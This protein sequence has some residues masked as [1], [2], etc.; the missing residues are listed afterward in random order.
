MNLFT[1]TYDLVRQI[2]PGKI[3]TYGAVAKALGDIRASR[4]VG[5]MMN[6]NPDAETMPCYKIIHSDGKLGG[7]GLGTDDK[8][9]R[10]QQD[11]IHVK[12]GKIQGFTNVFF[13]DFQ[14]TYPLYNFQ[15]EQ[16]TLSHQ[17]KT[18]DDFHNIETIGGI[19]VAYPQNEFEPAC[20]AYILMN[21]HTKEI[22]EQTT[23]TAPT[24]FPY[25]PG[26]LTYRELPLIQAVAHQWIHPPDVLMIDGNGILHPRGCGLASHAGLTLDLPTIG[27]AKNLLLGTL[28][29]NRIMVNGIPLGITL[30]SSPHAK[31]PLYLS[32]GHRISLE[33]CK[34]VVQHCCHTKH[35]EPLKQAHHLA[36]GT[37]RQQR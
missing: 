24:T 33:T 26:Y 18:E 27:V 19:D 32:P 14:T 23:I 16:T 11:N 4:A 13:D 25:I 28:Q 20:A 10:L 37:L 17:L 15:Q 6:Q 34:T 9:R 1:Y 8:I 29:N 22:L 5:R 7:F 12:D 36:T 21:Y 3:S 2:P 31:K 30:R 35:P